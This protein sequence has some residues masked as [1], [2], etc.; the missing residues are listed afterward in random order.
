MKILQI[1]CSDYARGGGGSIAMHRLYTGL[2]K[3]GL[4]CKILSAIKTLDSPDSSQIVRSVRTEKAIKKSCLIYC[5][6]FWRITLEQ[7]CL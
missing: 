3:A 7:S 4:D 6:S 5:R 2:T 1:N